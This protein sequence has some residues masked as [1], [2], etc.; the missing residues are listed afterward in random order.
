MFIYFKNFKSAHFKLVN[1]LLF[2]IITIF[3]LKNIIT[4]F[5][6]F[7]IF[8]L[9]ILNELTIVNFNHIYRTKK[10]FDY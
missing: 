4:V 1:I 3:V 10:R 2:F 6:I 7:Y 9:S 8:L 5:N